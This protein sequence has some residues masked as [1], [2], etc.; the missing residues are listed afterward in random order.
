MPCLDMFKLINRVCVMNQDN[1]L[2]IL[3][4]KL[5]Q[6]FDNK[7]SPNKLINLVESLLSNISISHHLYFDNKLT[8]QEVACLF[9]ASQGKTAEDTADILGI[10]PQTVYSYRKQ[11]KRKLKSESM[12][13][14]VF[15]GMR[16]GYI[17]HK[18]E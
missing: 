1:L 5:V 18:T 17:H 3:A 9:W 6:K 15:L 13:H 8:A 14:A 7:S 10:S 2:R 12:A 4:T 16:Y 11:I